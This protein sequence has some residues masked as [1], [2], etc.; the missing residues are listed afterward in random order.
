MNKQSFRVG[1]I[2]ITSGP[3]R[4][5]AKECC[6]YISYTYIHT[7]TYIYIYIYINMHKHRHRDTS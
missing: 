1:L 5:K 3:Q 7:Y 6:V 2:L 4:D